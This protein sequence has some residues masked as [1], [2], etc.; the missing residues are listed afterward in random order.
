VDEARA[1]LADRPQPESL[2]M[3]QGLRRRC[4]GSLAGARVTRRQIGSDYGWARRVD[5]RAEPLVDELERGLDA[6]PA[7]CEP[8][9]DLADGLD[10]LEVRLDR[11]LQPGAGLNGRSG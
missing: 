7:G 11:Q 2:E 3:T 4:H 5:P 10:C 6:R 1:Q 8:A 9:E